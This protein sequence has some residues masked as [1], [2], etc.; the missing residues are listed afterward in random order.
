MRL[1]TLGVVVAA[2][3]ALA[4]AQG[5]AAAQDIRGAFTLYPQASD[6]VA[7]AIETVV[8]PM[9]FIKK[10]LARKRLKETNQ[11]P[12]RIEITA[13]SSEV[14]ISTDDGEVVRTP[15]DGRPVEWTRKSDGETFMVTTVREGRVIRRTFRADDGQRA[16]SY[17]ISPDGGTLTMTVVVTSPQLPDPLT[18]TLVYRRAGS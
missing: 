18:Y 9:N 13:T 15:A 5:T 16:S 6:D 3:A 11:P 10:P 4:L 17:A 12:Q 7:K 14:S 2:L 8:T 1:R